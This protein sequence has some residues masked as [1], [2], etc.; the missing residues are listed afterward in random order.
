MT[1]KI[2]QVV[3]APARLVGVSCDFVSSM[4]AESDAQAVIPAAWQRLFDLVDRNAP[5]EHWSLGVMSDSGWPGRMSYFAGVRAVQSGVVPE[6]LVELA[7]AG[8]TY[9]GCEHVGSTETIAKTTAWFYAEYLPSSGLE[10][11]EGPHVEIYDERFNPSDPNSVMTIGA[12]V[13]P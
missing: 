4:D 13:A 1:A 11:V 5:H 10:I 7:F 2:V 8:G 3:L 9:V 6:G 12:P